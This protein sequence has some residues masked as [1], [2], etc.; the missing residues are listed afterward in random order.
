MRMLGKGMLLVLGK[1][2]VH[3]VGESCMEHIIIA[4][5]VSVLVAEI[6]MRGFTSLCERIG[7]GSLASRRDQSR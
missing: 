2:D 6:V 5:A 3:I 1:G 7:S 4:E